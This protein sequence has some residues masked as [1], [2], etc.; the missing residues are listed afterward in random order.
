MVLG[1][2]S[3]GAQAQYLQCLGSVVVVLGLSSYSA[4][5]Q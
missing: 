3:Y 5:A 4:R 2:S 1:L